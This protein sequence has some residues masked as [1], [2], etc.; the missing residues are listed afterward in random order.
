MKKKLFD[1]VAKIY[2]PS[3]AKPLDIE[4]YSYRG[5]TI[6]VFRRLINKWRPTPAGLMGYHK[7][8]YEYNKMP[9]SERVYYIDEF[10]MGI[11]DYFTKF[12]CEFERE[13]N[14]EIGDSMDK[15]EAKYRIQHYIDTH[16]AERILITQDI[17]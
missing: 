8:N 11:S 1:E 3:T 5:C 17:M 12:D 2:L 13:V 15:E 6:W 16:Y 9:Q 14:Q 7:G 4:E 10:W